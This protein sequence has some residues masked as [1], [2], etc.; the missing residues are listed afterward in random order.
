MLITKQFRW[1]GDPRSYERLFECA[2]ATFGFAV[3]RSPT[4]N[5]T[6]VFLV[7]VPI[8]GAVEQYEFPCE[9]RGL[10]T[11]AVSA[12]LNLIMFPARFE[13]TLEQLC[14]V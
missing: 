13:T 6:L 2:T 7:F 9:S 4:A 11:P 8:A 1:T 3:A 12:R 5:D 14:K 10:E